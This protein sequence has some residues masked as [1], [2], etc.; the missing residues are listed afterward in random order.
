M[1]SIKGFLESSLL[2][3]AEHDDSYHDDL[4]NIASNVKYLNDFQEV[5]KNSIYLF[6][7]SN[8]LV[9]VSMIRELISYKA[10]LDELY[11][12]IRVLMYKEYSYDFS[13]SPRIAQILIK[14]KGEDITVFKDIAESTDEND[15]ISVGISVCSLYSNYPNFEGIPEAVIGTFLEKIYICLL[16]NR[17]CN[18]LKIAISTNLLPILKNKDYM[19]YYRKI[20]NEVVQK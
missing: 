2:D 13:I 16:N 11:P 6:N 15:P 7:K 20:Y 9:V 12:V 8:I 3:D 5:F 4:E 19:G 14:I 18:K 10:K 17:N 1:N